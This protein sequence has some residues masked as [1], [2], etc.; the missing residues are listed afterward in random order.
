MFK[1]ILLILILFT[2]LG[3]FA[4]E[5]YL[6]AVVVSQNDGDVSVVLRS[7]EIAKVKKV[8]EAPDKIVLTLKGITSAPDISTLYKNAV[9]V[10]GFV[11][12]NEGANE[13]KI[14]IEAPN[15][16]KAD[17][18][19]E[20]P[21]SA[22]ITVVDNSIQERFI[23]SIISVLLLVGVMLSAKNVSNNPPQKD[24]NEVIKEREMALYRN[25]Q[26]EVATLPSMNY[27]L[28]GYSKHV[29]KGETIRSYESRMS[30]V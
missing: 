24:I 7:D 2:G 8:V 26:K 4:S 12:R 14:Y 22:P 19:F 29:L 30:K 1:K 16:S 23:W 13:L 15:I 21:N 28:K 27:R 9:D 25:F 6:N 10:N 18:I 3:A 5:N 20:T 17:I 11:I